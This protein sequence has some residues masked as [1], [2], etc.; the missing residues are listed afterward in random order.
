MNAPVNLEQPSGRPAKTSQITMGGVGGNALR[1]L[2]QLVTKRPQW[3]IGAILLALA[4]SAFYL[5]TT[6]PSFR[7][8][9]TLE[10]S[11]D[12]KEQGPS[13]TGEFRSQIL[14][15]IEFYETQYGLLR[16]PAMQAIG[17]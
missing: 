3:A 15:D 4:F 17:D 7:A 6:P 14:N 12:S 16:G 11:R 9:S 1:G 8:T 2:M 5:F 13:A 10:I